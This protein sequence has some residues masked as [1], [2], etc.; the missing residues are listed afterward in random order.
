MWSDE[1]HLDFIVAIMY[2]MQLCFVSLR[3]SSIPHPS[4][5]VRVTSTE[6]QPSFKKMHIHNCF[7]HEGL[8]LENSNELMSK[9]HAQVI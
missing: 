1:Q 2:S 9:Q 7:C 5:S 8:A 3:T 4:M 6:T